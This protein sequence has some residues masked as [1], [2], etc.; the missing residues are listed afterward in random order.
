HIARHDAPAHY[1]KICCLFQK[2][3]W[4]VLTQKTHFQSDAFGGSCV[5]DETAR[6]PYKGYGSLVWLLGGADALAADPKPDDMLIREAIYSLPEEIRKAAEDSYLE[7]TVHRWIGSVN[8]RP[9][10]R[11][12][13]EERHYPDPRGFPGLFIVGDYLYDST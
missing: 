2:P 3:F 13:D 4:R 5:Y 11:L 9:G 8:C 12:S 6:Y 1:L 7:G 10:S